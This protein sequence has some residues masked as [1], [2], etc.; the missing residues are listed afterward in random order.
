[1]TSRGAPIRLAC[2]RPR[3]A[4]ADARP[5]RP[6]SAPGTARW[7]LVD[8]G[9]WAAVCGQRTM[10]ERADGQTKGQHFAAARAAES[11]HRGPRRERFSASSLYHPPFALPA[12]M[13]GGLVVVDDSDKAIH[14]AGKWG[15]SGS[16]AEYKHTT[17][18]SVTQ[19]STA[20]FSFV[21]TSIGV[22]GTVSANA[23]GGALSFLLDNTRRAT[24]TAV[25][26]AGVVHHTELFAAAGLADGPHTLVITQ[27]A[28]PTPARSVLYFDYI[29]Y[30]ASADGPGPYY[31]DDRDQGIVYSPK[32]TDVADEMNFMHTSRASPG[33]GA[34]LTYT[35]SGRGISYY[36]PISAGARPNASFAIDGGPPALFVPPTT[37][38]AAAPNTLH[39]S[40]GDLPDGRHTLVVTAL[41]ADPLWADYLLVVP[42]LAASASASAGAGPSGSPSPA[43]GEHGTVRPEDEDDTSGPSVGA[44]AGGVIGGLVLLVF[45]ALG[46]LFLR[47]RR[48]RLR[49]AGARLGM[50]SQH[51][52]TSGPGPGAPESVVAPFLITHTPD[53]RYSDRPPSGPPCARLGARRG[54]V[55][56]PAREAAAGHAG[57][58]RRREAGR[59]GAGHA[60]GWAGLYGRGCWGAGGGGRGAAGVP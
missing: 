9:Q 57:R 7:R 36:A 40:S 51:S 27:A 43:P 15:T 13:P 22:Y 39:Y 37:A 60:Y 47:R 25:R 54:V 1:M 23:T 46:A 35:F 52:P 44:L 29:T 21:G 28:V 12:T 42:P 31:V 6:R 10:E 41:G 49:T 17:H 24:Y 18:C 56:L 26:A 45:L 20:S 33:P 14:Y 55:L 50:Y 5:T 58:R 59:R 8:A 30:A 48:R 53:D 16:P 32:W 19:G 4:H 3:R 11:P 34:K 38:A 2:E